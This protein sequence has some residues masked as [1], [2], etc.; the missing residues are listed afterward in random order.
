MLS[1]RRQVIVGASAAGTTAAL[2][3]RDHGY[4]GDIVLIDAGAERPYE[5]PPLS[6]GAGAGSSLVPILP[7]RAYSDR[8]TDLRLGVRVR[9]LD[10]SERRV[11]LDDGDSLTAESVLVAT[12]ARPRRLGVPGADLANVLVL[13][14][15]ADAVAFHAGSVPGRSW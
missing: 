10:V 12:G 14:A 8:R 1:R 3:L 2:A 6:K 4:D 15:A 7:E 9:A 13:R 11:H 5:R